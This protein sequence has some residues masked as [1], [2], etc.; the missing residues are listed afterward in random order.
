MDS[1]VCVVTGSSSG[2]GRAIAI[3]FAERGAKL[4]VCGD[5][6]HFPAKH[7][8]MNDHTPESSENYQPTDEV[9]C[10]PYGKGKALFI[11]TDVTSSEQ[12]KNLIAKALEAGGRLDVIVNNAG[13]SNHP[14]PLH[15]VPED[16]WDFIQGV[17]A[18]GPFLC[19]KYAIMEFLKQNP[20]K[21]GHRGRII[22]I[23][24]AGGLREAQGAAV[25]CASKAALISLTKTTALDYAPNKI[26]CNAICPGFIKTAMVEKLVPGAAF[27]AIFENMTPLGVLNT[28]DKEIGKAA[29]FLASAESSW[30]TGVIMPVDGGFAI[31]G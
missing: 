12:V 3:T 27:E 7:E 29:V 31:R 8:G 17:N 25:Y 5:I 9:I 30:M 18:R 16:Q 1:K 15:E 21:N 13:V 26:L 28:A 24:S 14:M 20:D 11:Q 22:N 10:R 6:R 4:V 19:S 23:S 2:I